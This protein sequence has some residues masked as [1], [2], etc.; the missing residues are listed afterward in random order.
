MTDS[1]PPAVMSTL[2]CL[3]VIG[4]TAAI[5]LLFF[6]VDFAAI[7]G[8]PEIPGG[9]LL[10]G[11]LYM[12]GQDH[13]TTAQ[14]WSQDNGWPIY[15]VRLGNRRVIFLN[16]FDV[17]REWLVIR[18]NYTIDRPLLYTFHNLVS[19]TSGRLD[20]APLTGHKF[21]KENMS[22]LQLLGPTLGTSAPENNGASW[23]P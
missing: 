23:V 3:F 20:A 5:Y 10:H 19:K 21:L 9:S 22:K 17:A 2:T 7:K 11:H 4:L 14:R 1:L 16:S 8:I 15:Q 13:A 6:Y 18:Q 12:L